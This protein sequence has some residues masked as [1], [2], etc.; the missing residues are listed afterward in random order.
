MQWYQQGDVTIQPVDVI[1]DG[2]K[3]V[4]PKGG[5]FILAEGE[6][7]GHAH[8]IQCDEGVILE[9]DE[10]GDLFL[11]LEKPADVVHEEHGTVNVEPGKYKVGRVKEYDHFQEEARFV[12][13]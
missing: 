13:D 12:A 9:E 6:V 11:T 8:A 2:V 3:T 4:Q 1:P 5:R 10:N 7:T